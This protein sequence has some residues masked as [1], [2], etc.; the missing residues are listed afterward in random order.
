M[1]MKL[2]MGV[3]ITIMNYCYFFRSTLIINL[4]IKLSSDTT[5]DIILVSNK[6][7]NKLTAVIISGNSIGGQSVTITNVQTGQSGITIITQ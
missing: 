6:L 3:I 5:G 7:V 1:V 2:K 4:R